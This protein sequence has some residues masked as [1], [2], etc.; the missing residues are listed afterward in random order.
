MSLLTI[1][2]P[3]IAALAER[4]ARPKGFY[5]LGAGAS[6]GLLPLAG[7]LPGL[8]TSEVAK[9]GSYSPDPQ[10]LGAI[11]S[12]LLRQSLSRTTATG[13]FLLWHTPEAVVNVL[14]QGLLMLKG[15]DDTPPQYEVFR[16]IGKPSTIFNFNLDGLATRFAGNDHFVLEPHGHIDRHWVEHPDL[17]S[18]L[19]DGFEPPH[20][21][22]KHL[23]G[24]EPSGIT[25]TSPF[26]I[27]WPKLAAAS[28]VFIIGYSFG[29]WNGLLDD[30]ESFLWLLSCV[31]ATAC[32]IF[33]IS[34]DPEP[35]AQRIEK[36][37]G[38][39]RVKRIV[40]SW[41]ELSALLISM[42]AKEPSVRRIS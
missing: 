39:P 33:V 34:V 10:S 11:R 6:A 24:P 18:M 38:Q 13:R 41:T 15:A 28:S 31:T 16:H 19:F 20:L 9:V 7:D 40:A 5:V 27:G 32:P 35:L 1:G 26:S 2:S 14:V 36:L 3:G 37:L 30:A 21:S 8:I 42:L 4:M 25:W 17:D 22:H 29:A 23:W 12:R